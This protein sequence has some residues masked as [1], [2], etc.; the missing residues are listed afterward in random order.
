[1]EGTSSTQYIKVTKS[2]EE[3]QKQAA[4]DHP[5]RLLTVSKGGSFFY[6]MQ[7][8]TSAEKGGAFKTELL[9]DP[10][11][12]SYP[13]A[14]LGK[15]APF[16]GRLAVI[17]DPVGLHV[18]DCTTG[19]E[20]RLIL[21]QTAI[22]AMIFSPKDSFLITCEKFVQGEKNLIVWDISSGLEVA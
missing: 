3:E 2:S 12:P 19:K 8:G 11:F 5:M 17:A 22:S 14:T 7:E 13:L 9:V 6:I 20:Q 1:M 15:F 18:V 16:A 10:S 21:K 4:H